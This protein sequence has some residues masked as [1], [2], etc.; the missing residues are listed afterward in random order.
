MS[1]RCWS[2]KLSAAEVGQGTAASGGKAQAAFFAGLRSYIEGMRVHMREEDEL[3]FP[4]VSQVL[5]Q[6]D[7]E[8]LARAFESVESQEIIDGVHDK[9]VDLAHRLAIS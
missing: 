9:Y 7:L 4:L 2:R 1:T 5:T 6:R 8:E 3:L